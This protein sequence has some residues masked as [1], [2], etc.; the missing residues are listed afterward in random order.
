MVG[1]TLNRSTDLSLREVAGGGLD[2]LAGHVLVVA[3]EV[4]VD[5]AAELPV[6]VGRAP[7]VHVTAAL[8]Q[9]QIYCF[10][11]GFQER[12]LKWKYSINRL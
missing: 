5:P 12:N 3:V 8:E 11:M 4:H 7:Q 6:V 10:Q 9:T 2:V 1:P